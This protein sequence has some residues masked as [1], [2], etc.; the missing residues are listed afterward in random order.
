MASQ[1]SKVHDDHGNRVGTI[2]AKQVIIVTKV[3]FP[4]AK[5]SQGSK[6]LLHKTLIGSVCDVCTLASPEHMQ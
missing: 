3:T 6:T 1:L 5:K 4:K 2:D